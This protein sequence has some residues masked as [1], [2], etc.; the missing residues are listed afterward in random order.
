MKTDGTT[1]QSNGC[2]ACSGFWKWLKPPH[3]RFFVKECNA[4][5][6]A[7]N[8][9]GSTNDRKQAD[10]RLFF[11]MVYKS[12]DHYRDRK[13]TSMWW[14]VTLAFGY[15]LAVRTFGKKRFNLIKP[16]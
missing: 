4:H 10:K 3:K 9:G 16:I 2:G 14:F 11:D 5:D 7:Y 13:A 8:I 12:V 6:E 1:T 15:Y